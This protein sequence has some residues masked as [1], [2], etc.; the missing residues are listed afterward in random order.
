VA[1]PFLI[2][3]KLKRGAFDREAAEAAKIAR[4]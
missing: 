1:A 4:P 2:Y 3:L